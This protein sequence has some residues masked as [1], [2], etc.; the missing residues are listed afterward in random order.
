MFKYLKATN[1]EAKLFYDIKVAIKKAT[2]IE[3]EKYSQVWEQA[4]Q[5]SE[6]SQEVINRVLNMIQ[7]EK[8]L[9]AKKR[10]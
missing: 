6:N 7:E 2:E 3:L 5:N 4:K 1:E 10:H 8:N 9:R